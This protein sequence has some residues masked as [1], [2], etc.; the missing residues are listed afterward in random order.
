MSLVEQA[1]EY[2]FPLLEKYCKNYPY[3]NPTHTELVYTRAS[4]LGLAENVNSEDLEDL[5]LAC[6]FH[7]TGFTE[8][9][10]KNEFIGARIARKWLEEKNHPKERIEKIE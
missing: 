2:I 8:Q 1:K 4:Y 9:Y 7:D 10:E 5:Q 3:H 6:I